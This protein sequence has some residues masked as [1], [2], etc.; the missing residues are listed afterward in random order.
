LSTE[1]KNKAR[2][3]IIDDANGGP[4]PTSKCNGS[5]LVFRNV[6]DAMVMAVLLLAIAALTGGWVF[7]I[8]WMA[9]KVIQWIFA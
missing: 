6:K 4:V 1:R 7:A 8:G 9:L 2:I 3:A 5:P